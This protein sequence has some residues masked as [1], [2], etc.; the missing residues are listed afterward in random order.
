MRNRKQHR[1]GKKA[2]QKM[3]E[4]SAIAEGI[5]K[6][7]LCSA[8]HGGLTKIDFEAGYCTQCGTKLKGNN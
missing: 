1:K 5:I 6:R 4:L 3:A 7:D 8:C 2:S